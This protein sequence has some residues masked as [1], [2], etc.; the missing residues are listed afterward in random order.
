MSELEIPREPIHILLVEADPEDI[1]TIWNMLHEKSRYQIHVEAVTGLE[2]A[3]DRLND[4][5]IDVILLD[6][7]LVSYQAET[8]A[9]RTILDA[10]PDV[11]LLVLTELENEEAGLRALEAGAQDYLL[12]EEMATRALIRA[13][14]Y[15]V[16]RQRAAALVRAADERLRAATNSVIDYAII[17]LDTQGRITDWNVGA[18]HTFGFHEEEVL[19]QPFDLLFTPEDRAAGVPQQ[20][21]AKVREQ[22]F[23]EDE[24]WHIRKDGSRFYASGMTRPIHGPTDALQG[25]IKIARDTTM[26]LQAEKELHASQ[27]QLRRS[28]DTFYRLIQN[29]PFGVY[30]V[31]ADFRLQEVSQGAQK[32]FRNIR[33]LIGRDFAEVLRIIWE[34]PFATEAINHFRHTLETGEPYTAPNTVEQRRDIEGVE[35]YDWRIERINMP[36]GRFGVVCYFYDLTERQE[37]ETALRKSEEERAALFVREQTARREAERAVATQRL[38]LGMISHELRTPLTSIKGFSSTLLADDVTFTLERNREFVQIIEEEADKLSDLVEQLLDLVQMQTGTFRV[39]AIPT[40]LEAIVDK[41]MPELQTLAAQH[42]L[43]VSLPAGLPPMFADRQRMGQVLV[44]LV[45][46]AAKFSPA[47]TRIT[48]SA[49]QTGDYVQISVSD[50]GQGIPYAERRLVFDVFHQVTSE[51]RRQPGSGLGL[52]ICKG[53]VEAHRGTIWIEDR[54]APGTT[55]SFTLPLAAKRED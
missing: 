41:A 37:W 14:Q 29:N 26:R 35:A 50:E 33:P 42:Q 27:E 2:A 6:L 40:R 5:D 39:N 45:G 25:Y 18:A 43:E 55:I 17:F 46:N 20:E 38:F 32:V 21:L 34:E 24:R 51:G 3:L 52:T 28:H 11:A 9:V 7:S 48:L 47:Q 30:V 49:Q 54:A 23:A 16:E 36:D 31:D 13:L 1:R 4:H 15:A 8:D 22:G 12:K 53:L 44:N 19:E 10:Q